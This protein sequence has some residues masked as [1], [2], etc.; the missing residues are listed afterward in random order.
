MVPSFHTKAT[1]SSTTSHTGAGR[2]AS[3]AATAAGWNIAIRIIIQS[4]T[5]KPKKKNE[6]SIRGAQW[7]TKNII[8]AY[9]I[10]L[11]IFSISICKI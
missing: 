4:E 5:W 10:V 6:T 2:Q 9:L 8:H 3:N 7:G 1:F 11:W